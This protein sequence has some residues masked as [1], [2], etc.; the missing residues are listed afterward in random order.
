[1]TGI[2]HFALKLAPYAVPAMIFSVIVK[3]GFD[4]IIALGLFVLG[5][6]SM[7]LLAPVRHDVDLAQV[8]REA[9][10]VEFFRDIKDVL[11]TAFSTARAAP[12][13]RRRWRRRAS[14]SAWR[15]PPRA[16]CC[17]SAPP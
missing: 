10:P 6:V 17:R 4:I 13:C 7:L 14:D 5:C 11:V 15:H 8:P 9:Q 12:R 3:V 16:S 1:M 2:V